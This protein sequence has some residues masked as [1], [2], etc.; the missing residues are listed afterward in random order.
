MISTRQ[1]MNFDLIE[2]LSKKLSGIERMKQYF[3]DAT[4]HSCSRCENFGVN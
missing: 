4:M 1:N 3:N 2:E